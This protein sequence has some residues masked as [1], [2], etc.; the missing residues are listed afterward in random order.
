MT[1]KLRGDR[2]WFDER[3]AHV[4]ACDL[5]AQGLTEGPDPELGQVVDSGAAPDTASGYGG[6]VD[7][8]G[9]PPRR[10]LGGLQEVGKCGVGDV[11]Q[12]LDV[13]VHHPL[14]LLGRRV[15]D[16]PEQHYSSVVEDRIQPSKL[17]DRLLDCGYRLLLVR[18]VRLDGKRLAAVL[19]YLLSQPLQPVLAPGDD[20]HRSTLPSKRLRCRLTYTAARASYER[21]RPV[22][23]LSHPQSSLRVGKGCQ[24]MSFPMNVGSN[25]TPVRRRSL[26]FR[27]QGVRRVFPTLSWDAGPSAWYA[28]ILWNVAGMSEK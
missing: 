16:R 8:I 26:R 13:Q 1:L 22:E 23:S 3:D 21:H 15:L 11:Q 28:G 17:K 24:A 12:A 5:L 27:A 2:A 19:L 10:V 7:E 6:R 14:P 20:G 25:R 4:P 9:N 18:Y